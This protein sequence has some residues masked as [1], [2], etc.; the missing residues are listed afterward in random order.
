MRYLFVLLIILCLNQPT[1]KYCPFFLPL[2]PVLQGQP[3]ASIYSL[4]PLFINS[5]KAALISIPEVVGMRYES[6]SI[7]FMFYR[8]PCCTQETDHTPFLLTE[9]K[10][11]IP[12]LIF[13]LYFQMQAFSA[14]LHLSKLD[15]LVLGM[16]LNCRIC[17]SPQESY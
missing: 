14:S 9:V 5:A 10:F 11:F 1:L 7:K 16:H 8:K 3:T 13:Y 6:L 2:Q 12:S 17:I 15:G 4:S